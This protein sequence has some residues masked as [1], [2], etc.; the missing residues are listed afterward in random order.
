MFGLQ[1]L[2]V[3]IGLIGLNLTALAVSL[4]APFWFDLLNKIMSIRAVGKSPG[5]R[6][7]AKTSPAR[8]QVLSREFH[9]QPPKP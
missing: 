8:Q 1:M 9:R 7:A 4:G 6:E 2:D 3:A 5:D